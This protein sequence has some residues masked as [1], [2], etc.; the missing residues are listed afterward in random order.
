MVNREELLAEYW[1]TY[2][3]MSGEDREQYL[4]ELFTE[5]I[6]MWDKRVLEDEIVLIKKEYM[7]HN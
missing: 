3:K 2:D 6:N 4:L 7:E 1:Q 5:Q